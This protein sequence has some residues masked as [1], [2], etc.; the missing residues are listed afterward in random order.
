M[1]R[2][3][4][5]FA[6][7]VPEVVKLAFDDGVPSEGKFGPQFFFTWDDGRASYLDPDAR[8]KLLAAGA[9]KGDQV[10]IVKV[11]GYITVAGAR[12]KTTDWRV[13]RIPGPAAAPQMAKPEEAAPK[14]QSHAGDQPHV[15]T[16]GNGNGAGKSN[17]NGHTEVPFVGTNHGQ[18]LLSALVNTID[19]CIAA[20]QYAKAK[21]RELRF[22]NQDIRAIAISFFIQ[23]SRENGR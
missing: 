19:M 14:P 4:V 1:P 10:E 5:R 22:D 21:G 11:A 3:L 20:E 17:G 12:K 8:A 23:H 9:R 7:N 18:Y 6:D 16:N 2:E 15:S 13:Q